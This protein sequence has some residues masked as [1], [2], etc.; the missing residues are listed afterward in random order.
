VALSG[1]R[2]E[3]VIFEEEL[4]PQNSSKKGKKKEYE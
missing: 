4:Q 1:E 3:L 2:Q